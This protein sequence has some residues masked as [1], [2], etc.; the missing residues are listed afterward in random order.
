MIIEPLTAETRTN[1]VSLFYTCYNRTHCQEQVRY[2]LSF[3]AAA[4]SADF[5]GSRPFQIV[6]VGT[7][8]AGLW[9]LLAAP[10]A[11]AVIADCCDLDVADDE[12]M[13][14]SDIFCPGLR[15]VGDFEGVAMLAAPNPLVLHNTGRQ[16]PTEKL[17]GVYKALAAGKK[18]HVE[19]TRLTPEHIAL[20]AS[21]L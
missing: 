5:G 18:L 11:D 17:Q 20:L 7:G 21:E 16:F 3:C 12:L 8:R 4:G 13:L 9:A 2:L 19:T 6:L 1:E 14:G 15:N 10:A